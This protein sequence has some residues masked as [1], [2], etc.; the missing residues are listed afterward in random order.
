MNQIINGR[1]YD[2]VTEDAIIQVK[3]TYSAVDKPKNFLNKST[4]TQIKETINLSGQQEKRA[5]FWFKY[6][7]HPD[8]RSYIEQKG[9]LVITGLGD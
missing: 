1:E 2:A 9:G 8:V 6:G 7:V 5:E 3:R 4:R